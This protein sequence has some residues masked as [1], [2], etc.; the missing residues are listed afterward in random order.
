MADIPT[1]E[2]AAAEA[3]TAKPP[4]R[5]R[6]VL[7]IAVTFIALAAAGAGGWL[8]LRPGGAKSK[9]ANQ[10]RKASGPA[11]YVSLDPPFVTNFQPNQVAR[12]L[13][14]SVEVLTHDKK[15]V[16]LIKAN[17]PVIRNNLL[18]LFSDQKYSTL[19]TAAGKDH[20]RAQALAAVRKVVAAN[21]GDANEV[22]AIYFTSFVMQ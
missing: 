9:T 19:E 17:N 1:L 10:I 20:L 2:P 7:I 18:L 5:S 22:D 4:K 8:F 13:Q 15:T 3:T 14:V 16:E 12:F 11:R 21:G 6:R